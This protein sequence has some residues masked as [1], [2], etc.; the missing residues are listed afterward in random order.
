MSDFLWDLI[1]S[2]NF[3]AFGVLLASSLFGL[4]LAQI[5][6][7]F[8]HGLRI[9]L[10]I[11]LAV[12]AIYLSVN[13][14]RLLESPIN[15]NNLAENLFSNLAT[16]FVSSALF[17]PLVLILWDDLQNFEDELVGRL[18]LSIIV[19]IMIAVI[20][21]LL[22][23]TNNI[24][25][26]EW[27][28]PTMRRVVPVALSNLGIELTSLVIPWIMAGFF[29]GLVAIAGKLQ[30]LNLLV[31]LL[32]LLIIGFIG[33]VFF[34]LVLNNPS[35]PKINPNL[36]APIIGA[37]ISTL[38]FNPQIMKTGGTAIIFFLVFLGFVF[39]MAAILLYSDQSDGTIF[40]F[41]MCIE[42]MGALTA[43]IVLEEYKSKT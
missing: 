26:W 19:V 42:F 32:V 28:P 27:L 25:Y 14:D 16:E 5:I 21:I 18:I 30:F 43:N 22:L 39:S 7:Q 2:P 6:R 15:Q 40:A 34:T 37:V 23:Y 9:I 35:S 24:R 17:V 13:I 8:Y 11:A 29:I 4:F 1:T 10:L 20:A 38:F 33:F 36:I 31:C 41:N 3:F 12:G